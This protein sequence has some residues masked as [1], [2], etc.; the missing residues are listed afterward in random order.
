MFREDGNE[1]TDSQR[2]A[3]GSSIAS[4]ASV[5]GSPRTRLEEA[6]V[7]V[8]AERQFY[9]P[10]VTSA[11]MKQ[12]LKGLR[13]GDWVAVEGFPGASGRGELS[14][15]PRQVRLLAPVARPAGLP[16]AGSIESLETRARERSLALA[17]D[18]PQGRAPFVKR[19]AMVSQLRRS[20]EARGFLEVE[21]PILQAQAGGASATPFET[22]AAALSGPA[23]MRIAPELYLKMLVAGGMGR[24]FELGKVFRNEGMDATHHPEFTTAELY[25][26]HCSV[27]ELAVMTRELMADAAVSVRGSPSAV[28]EVTVPAEWLVG[29]HR[30]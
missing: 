13:R 4:H 26:P 18:G 1:D 3:E 21:T 25:A 20:L 8:L 14:I 6:R 11:T 23:S 30:V 17:S 12:E 19:A 27:Q 10:R 16:P 2:G 15:V 28:I 29:A 9:R 7:Q 22:H 24:V 5:R